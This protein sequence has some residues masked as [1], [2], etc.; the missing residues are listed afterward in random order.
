MVTSL[1]YRND[2]QLSHYNGQ[3]TF[4]ELKLYSSQR[5][6]LGPITDL[7]GSRID[8]VALL[9]IDH[10]PS[11][12]RLVRNILVDHSIEA[13]WLRVGCRHH[14]LR[15]AC[16]FRCIIIDAHAGVQWV[17]LADEPD[18]GGVHAAILYG[19]NLLKGYSLVRKRLLCEESLHH[20]YQFNFVLKL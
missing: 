15:A 4:L 16:W 1:K 6:D 3:R 12:V 2:N 11:R 8:N 5:G 7:I 17:P 13:H 14:W 10:D 20:F 19:I 18:H 9:V